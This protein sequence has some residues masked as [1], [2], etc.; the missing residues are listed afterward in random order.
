[1]TPTTHADVARL[2]H[3]ALRLRE[4]GIDSQSK[5]E[6]L[7]R[8]AQAQP[9]SEGAR[10]VVR[11]G[12]PGGLA[13]VARALL[14][15]QSP[16]RP[17]PTDPK[18]VERLM[19]YDDITSIWKRWDDAVTANLEEI[20]SNDEL[21]AWRASVEKDRRASEEAQAEMQE[22]GGWPVHEAFGHDRYLEGAANAFYDLGREGI[23]DRSI[24]VITATLKFYLV[25][26]AVYSVNLGTHQ[27]VSSIASTVAVTPALG[28]KTKTAG[29]FDAADTAFTAV[30]GAQS[31]ALVL[32]QTSAVGGGADV[33]TSAQRLVGYV[34]TATGLPV[35]PN[36]GDIN[37]IFDSGA[38]RI[39]KL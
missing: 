27:F 5:V 32:A 33:A 7:A 16:E 23:L 26:S 36:G 24:D 28:S 22:T 21:T 29:V 15:A 19:T 39:F 8:S 9:R 25:D 4:S 30:S 2:A 12:A 38:N 14:D 17:G 34:D 18:L 35:T 11:A 20:L 6:Q 31:E 1:M 13:G 37:L 3:R 10:Q